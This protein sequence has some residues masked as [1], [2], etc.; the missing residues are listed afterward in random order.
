[1][2]R[3]I[4]IHRQIGFADFHIVRGETYLSMNKYEAAH[5]RFEESLRLA[6]ENPLVYFRLP[7]SLKGM[8]RLNPARLYYR[9]YLLLEPKGR[10]AGLAKERIKEVAKP[11]GT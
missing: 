6:P 10:F 11:M 2:R 9:K 7:Q 1:M 3:F 5:E 8:Q 4:F